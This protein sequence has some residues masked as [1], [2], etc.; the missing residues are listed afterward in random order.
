VALVVRVLV[1]VQVGWV[2]LQEEHVRVEVL[3]WIAVRP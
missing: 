1:V 2:V 3:L